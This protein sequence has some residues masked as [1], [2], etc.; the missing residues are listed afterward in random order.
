VFERLLDWADVVVHNYRPAA[1]A[2]LGIDAD[3]VR[4]TRPHLIHVTIVGFGSTGPKAGHPAYDHVIQAMSGICDRQR[5]PRTDEPAMVRNGIVDKLT[6]WAMAQAVCAALV[7][8]ATT[9]EGR[10]V[11]VC[12]L[13]VNV[14]TLWPDG[15]MNHTVLHP[16]N[17]RPDLAK[18]FR[19]WPTLDGHI[20]FISLTPRQV[21]NIRDAFELSE[22]AIATAGSVRIVAV[23]RLAGRAIAQLTTEEVLARLDAHDVPASPVVALAELHAAPQIVA[24]GT[25]E[26]FEHPVLGTIR[27][28]APPVRFGGDNPSA[29]RPAARLGAHNDEIFA[30]LEG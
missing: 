22:D 1:A 24:N 19:L 26:E 15:M 9:G 30:M 14:A 8:R 20:S 3:A 4:A 7:G 23:T 16:V 11:E 6:G 25:V 18:G 21:E 10:C 29:L 5:D 2:A 13:D 17:Q 12:M 28:A 27:Q